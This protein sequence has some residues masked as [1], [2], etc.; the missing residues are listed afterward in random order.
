MK[1]QDVPLG[2]DKM[3]RST[4]TDV[5]PGENLDPGTS[6][7]LARAHQRNARAASQVLVAPVPRPHLRR[8]TP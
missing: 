4:A 3:F 6:V 5:L 7:V 8:Y 2:M 1:G